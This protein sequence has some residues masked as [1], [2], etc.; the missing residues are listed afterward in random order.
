MT[1]P[2]VPYATTYC[3]TY[4]ALEWETGVGGGKYV[5]GHLFLAPYLPVYDIR[6]Q[7]YK[8][9]QKKRHT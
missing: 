3:H 1:C 7:I 8:R 5:F 6:D 4:M 2:I 9:V